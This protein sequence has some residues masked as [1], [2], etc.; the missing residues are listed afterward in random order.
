VKEPRH[1][2]S[3]TSLVRVPDGGGDTERD[4]RRKCGGASARPLLF[5]PEVFQVDGEKIGA[6]ARERFA[7]QRPIQCTVKFPSIEWDA[8][9]DR[10][11][12]RD[13]EGG[14]ASQHPAAQHTCTHQLVV[15]RGQPADKRS[16]WDLR[17]ERNAARRPRNAGASERDGGRE[18]LPIELLGPHIRI[19]RAGPAQT[20]QEGSIVGRAAPGI[21]AIIGALELGC[22]SDTTHTPIGGQRGQCITWAVQDERAERSVQ[23]VEAEDQEAGPVGVRSCSVASR[24]GGHGHAFGTGHKRTDPPPTPGQEGQE[25]GRRRRAAGV[26]VREGPE[27]HAWDLLAG[28]DTG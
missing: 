13:Q 16:G 18:P 4:G 25:G 10:A 17:L 24:R 1:A 22:Q 8:V 14:R 19:V 3:S 2:L 5:G 12:A 15:P 9:S 11:E 27:E 26:R 20:N 28:P 6:V 23:W 7:V 21:E